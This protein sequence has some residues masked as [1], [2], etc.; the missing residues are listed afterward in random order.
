[1][2]KDELNPNRSILHYNFSRFSRWIGAFV[3][4]G[5]IAVACSNSAAAQDRQDQD[6]NPPPPPSA[7]GPQDDQA[8]PPPQASPDSRPVISRD[9][10][11]QDPNQDPNPNPNQ[12]QYPTQYPNGHPIQQP[13]M[14]NRRPMPRANYGPVPA[15]LTIP[16]GTVLFTRILEPLSSDHNHAG[17]SFTATLDRPIIVNGW[18]VARRGQTILGKVTTA[19]KAGRVKGVSQLGLEL[20][21]ITVVDGQQLPVLTELWKGSAGTSHGADAAGIATTT[22]VGTIIGAAADGGAGAGIGAGAGA[23]AGIA[24]VLLTR[25]KPTVIGPEALLSFQIKDPVTISTANS[26]QAFQPVGP[27]DYNS[28]PSLRQRG[29]GYVAYPPPYYT[30]CGPY[31]G[32]AP[33]YGYYGPYIGFGY[34]GG[35]Y[36]GGFG[37]YGFRR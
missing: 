34:Y 36:R 30:T 1:M 35:F 33:Y 7:Q 10:I 25:G 28:S 14:Q 13:P 8:P 19:Q 11:P 20:T 22:G 23:V 21:D 9:T 27:H 5:A 32:C 24:M 3:L 29:D 16:P 4:A 26:Q 6:Q 2:T 31:W 12:N 37:H 17:D 18:V 15:N